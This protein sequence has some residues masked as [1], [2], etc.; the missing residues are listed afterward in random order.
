MPTLH[1]KEKLLLY[2]SNIWNFGDG[3]LGPLF[4][5]FAERIGGNILDISW[6]WA[7]YLICTG[8]FT[9]IIGKLSDGLN[10]ERMLVFGYALT[11][12]FTFGYLFV[13]TP[14]HLFIIQAGLGLALALSN[15]T[16]MALYDKYSDGPN[17]GYIWGLADGE[18]KIMLGL[19]I[20]VGG[21]IV[22]FFS[23]TALFIIMGVIQSIATIYQAQILDVV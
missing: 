2:G 8:V 11:S 16:W 18:S 9:I 14:I 1:R 3:M 12:L 20:I 7:T 10:K 13:S 17:D 21:F 4:A 6:A 23:F 5:V 19:A 15:P 22:N